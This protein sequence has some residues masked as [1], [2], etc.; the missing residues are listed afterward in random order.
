MQGSRVLR[1]VDY[2]TQILEGAVK[3]WGLCSPDGQCRP[4]K[5]FKRQLAKYSAEFGLGHLKS[6]T[7][8]GHQKAVKSLTKA[9]SIDPTYWRGLAY[10]VAAYLG[11]KP[12]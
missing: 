7:N 3:Q 8:A 2:R 11:W 5:Q 12:K 9:L 10:L 1:E 6:G 4:E